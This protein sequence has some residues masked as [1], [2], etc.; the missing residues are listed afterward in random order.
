VYSKDAVPEDVP[1]VPL[2]PAAGAV[3]EL[4]WALKQAQLAASTSD[5]RRLVEQ[6]GVEVDGA[7]ATDPKMRLEPGHEYLVRV[8]SKNRRF[9]K[10]RVN[11]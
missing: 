6:G 7:R 5:A 8:G 10:I 4:A 1:V 11:A 2:T 3:A 9:A